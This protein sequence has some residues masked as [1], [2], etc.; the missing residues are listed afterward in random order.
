[1]TGWRGWLAGEIREKGNGAKLVTSR[2]WVHGCALCNS[3][4]GGLSSTSFYTR[5]LAQC[6]LWATS[7]AF[8][9]SSHRNHLMK[10]ALPEVTD[11]NTEGHGSSHRV[12][13]MWTWIA[14]QG[15]AS[16]THILST[17]PSP[18]FWTSVAIL[19]S[20]KESWINPSVSCALAMDDEDLAE[21]DWLRCN[22]FCSLTW[23]L[24]FLFW[25]FWFWDNDPYELN[26]VPKFMRW[27]PNP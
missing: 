27:S 8:C 16:G 5:G 1:M 7:P 12:G 23:P 25:T 4:K 20:G 19:S 9:S 18:F 17:S 11:E 15:S 26:G 22:A 6:L 13:P 14:A 24:L 10:H 2:G 21:P 3:F